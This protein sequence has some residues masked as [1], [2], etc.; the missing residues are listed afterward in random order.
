[1]VGDDCGCQKANVPVVLL[2]PTGD[3]SAKL[4]NPDDA[5]NQRAELIRKIAAE[6]KVLLG[7]VFA[8]WVAEVKKAR[9]RPICSV[10]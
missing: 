8:A 1:M 5:L 7:D 2:T 10:R 3:S 4:E 9:R 6:Q